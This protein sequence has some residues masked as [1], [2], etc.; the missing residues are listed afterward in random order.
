MTGFSAESSVFNVVDW[1]VLFD[2]S[3]PP[4]GSYDCVQ[5]ASWWGASVSRSPAR[6]YANV[7]KPWGAC[8]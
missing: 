7:R 1:I 6:M 4:H 5:I 8:L 2:R 3:I